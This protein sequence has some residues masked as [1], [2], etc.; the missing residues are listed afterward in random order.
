MGLRRA[1]YQ[2]ASSPPLLHWKNFGIQALSIRFCKLRQLV[3]LGDLPRRLL[4]GR[5]S[6]ANRVQ[7]KRCKHVV[8][9]HAA[10]Y[11]A[12]DPLNTHVVKANPM[13]ARSHE[14]YFS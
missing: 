11:N 2:A 10:Q 3:A 5:N 13:Y 14:I 12:F 6:Q 4:N 8:K 9:I 7:A 1:Y